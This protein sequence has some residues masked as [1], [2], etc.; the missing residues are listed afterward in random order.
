[1][2]AKWLKEMV[3]HMSIT[4]KQT[5]LEFMANSE[6]YWVEET[7]FGILILMFLKH[8]LC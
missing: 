8:Y 3:T 1:M 4:S 7:L 6:M 5:G 2:S